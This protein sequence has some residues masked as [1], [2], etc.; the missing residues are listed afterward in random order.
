MNNLIIVIKLYYQNYIYSR[1]IRRLFLRK[2]WIK[3]MKYIIHIPK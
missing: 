2:K 1:N 3:K